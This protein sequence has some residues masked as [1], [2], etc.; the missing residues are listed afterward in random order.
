MAQR[1]Q[2]GFAEG[3]AAVPVRTRGGCPWKIVA[4]VTFPNA[5]GKSQSRMRSRQRGGLSH[6]RLCFPISFFGGGDARAWSGGGISPPKVLQES[7]LK[8]GKQAG[9]FL[10]GEENT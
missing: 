4:A 3:A 7:K 10:P 9:K 1:K 6:P 8:A 5:S 2:T